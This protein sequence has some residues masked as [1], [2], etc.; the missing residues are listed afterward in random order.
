MAQVALL[1]TSVSD[2]MTKNKHKTLIHKLCICI[3][4]YAARA[5]TTVL[6]R[7][8]NKYINR[9]INIYLFLRFS[10]TL[11]FKRK[12]TLPSAGC[13]VISIA[14]EYGLFKSCFM[15]LENATSMAQGQQNSTLGQMSLATVLSWLPPASLQIAELSK[16][17]SRLTSVEK[18]NV[19]VVESDQRLSRLA[20]GTEYT[21]FTQ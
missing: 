8:I 19:I 11:Q 6:T 10:L 3:T 21:H 16:S 20:W 4:M 2:K 9:E 18:A 1:S 5:R 15:P 14:D 17:A 7:W 12:K 13:L